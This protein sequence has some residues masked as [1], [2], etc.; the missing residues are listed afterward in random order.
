[1]VL[2]WIPVLM[3]ILMLLAIFTTGVALTLAAA[4]V[5]Y[6]DVNYLWGILVQILFYATPDHLRRRQPR[7]FRGRSS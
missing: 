7:T 3:V 1:M 2:P 4:N 6:H 5:F